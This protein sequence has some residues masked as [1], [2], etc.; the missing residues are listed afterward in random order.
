[1]WRGH[2]GKRL[3]SQVEA[4]REREREREG[5][6]RERERREA[7]QLPQQS[8]GHLQMILD[9][10]SGPRGMTVCLWIDPCDKKRNFRKLTSE[11]PDSKLEIRF[12]VMGF[13]FE[14]VEIRPENSQNKHF[15]KSYSGAIEEEQSIFTHDAQTCH[16]A[17]SILEPVER[18]QEA[19]LQ[20]KQARKLALV[21]IL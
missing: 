19:G 5:R 16:C 2:L 21:R 1:M 14:E 9:Q 8:Q 20:I 6:Q 10:S 4:A 12:S 11:F 17:V 7:T 3:G 18:F 15:R 13:V